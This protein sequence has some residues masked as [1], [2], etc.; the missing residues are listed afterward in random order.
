MN[1][2]YYL[3]Q[4]KKSKDFLQFIKENPTAYLCS[5]FFIIDKQENDNK[6]HLD[7]FVPGKEKIFSFEIEGEGKMTIL[8]CLDKTIPEKIIVNFN[9]DFEDIQDKIM[10]KIRQ[11]GINN[12]VQK[13]ILSM[14]KIDDKNFLMGTV[15]LSMFGLLKVV[16][17]L[18]ENKI[19]DFQ[20]KSFFDMVSVF[21]K[22]H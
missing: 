9:L 16:I 3:E 21:K 12:R 11:Q 15:F 7:F 8:D 4:L 13:Y 22:N 1:I 19:T 18:D 6:Q 5:G 14:Q 20:K 2:Q 10:D 17:N